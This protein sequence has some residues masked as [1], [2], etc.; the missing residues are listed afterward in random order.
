MNDHG[1]E[2]LRSIIYKNM[3]EKDTDELIVIRRMHTEQGWS[4]EALEVVE[5]I[6]AERLG[7]LPPADEEGADL[8]EE[9]NEDV[10]TEFNA[11]FYRRL[12]RWAS[13]LSWVSLAISAFIVVLGLLGLIPILSNQ[14]DVSFLPSFIAN[15]IQFLVTGAFS[16][17][18]LQ[19]IAG[20]ITL[21]LDLRLDVQ[22]IARS[23]DGRNTNGR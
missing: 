9:L 12:A 13:I 1:P 8:E 16:F 19:V 2:S 17:I 3:Q 22:S 23:L 15:V 6:L 5:Q 11:A 21:F 10:K 14:S 4:D 20:G 18:V 7:A